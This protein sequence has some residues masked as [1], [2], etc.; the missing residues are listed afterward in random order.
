MARTCSTK[1]RCLA[2]LGA[3]LGF[4]VT[5]LMA[6]VSRADKSSTSIE[7][8]YDLGEIQSPRAL[9]MGG[10]QV[11]M[12]SSTAALYLNPANLALTRVYHFEAEGSYSPQARRES[13]GGAVADSSSSALRGGFAGTYNKMDPDGIDRTW[14]DLRLALAY[15]FSD[16][17]AF[18]ATGRYLRT[19][20]ADDAGPFG[21]SLA[22]GGT[23]TGPVFNNF[24]FD[25]GLTAMPVDGLHIGVVGKNLTNPGIALAP[26]TVTGAIGYQ[27][28]M[29]AVETDLLTD[30][31]TWNEAKERIMVGG[32]IFLANHVPLRL[33]YRY[34]DG[35]R[36]HSISGGVGY[37]DKQFSAEFGLRQDV[38]GDHPATMMALAL[39]YFYETAG[40]SS[41]AV[42]ATDGI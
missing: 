23:A 2:S 7:Q 16:R 24:T 21:A 40:A 27:N 25:A 20:Q 41:T 30:F 22:S 14:T 42:D 29:F 17:I 31:T 35:M 3:S 8:G 34:D 12:G 32:E 38:V 15:A 37:I 1:T 36:V 19:T 18:G 4:A 6:T 26:T 33:G 28:G 13:V 11:A 10:A 39:R 9:G 5:M